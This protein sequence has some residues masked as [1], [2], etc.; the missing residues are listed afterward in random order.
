MSTEPAANAHRREEDEE[1]SLDRERSSDEKK[2]DTSAGAGQDEENQQSSPKPVGFW[3]PKLNDVRKE[4]FGKWL[5]TS[6]HCL[7]NELCALAVD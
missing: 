2:E 7:L 3:D 4:A 6:T 5:L 1:R